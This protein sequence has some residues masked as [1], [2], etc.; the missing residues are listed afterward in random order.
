[1]KITI[2]GAGN[3]GTQIACHC[4]EKG[5]DVIM[6]TSRPNDISN[7][8]YVVDEN[9]KVIHRGIISQATNDPKIAFENADVVFITMPATMMKVNAERIYPYVYNQMKICLVPGIGGGECAFKKCIDKG[10]TLFALQRVPSVAR[11]VEYGRVTRVVG[12]RN[13]LFVAAIPHKETEWCRCFIEDIFEINTSCI[14]NYLNITLTPSNPVMH[15]TR[16]KCLFEDWHEGVFYDNVPLFYEDWDDKSS[17]LLLK[18]DA[19]VQMICQALKSFNLSYVKSLKDHYESYNVKDMTNKIRSIKGF[20]GLTSPVVEIEG[21]GFIPDFDSRYFSSDFPYGLSILIQV[22]NMIGV[23]V[24]TMQSVYDW[25]E[26]I[27]GQREQFSFKEYGIE[28]YD[29]FLE[30][31]SN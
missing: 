1:M 16:L 25:Y 10:A 2:V 8:L 19:E 3:I 20:K 4:S 22:A 18:C 14:P 15:T 11:L 17:E 24:P 30:F 29:H 26:Q 5:H 6:Y 27:C 23:Q 13:E 7:K 9:N 28:N 21:K 31:Y 12:Y